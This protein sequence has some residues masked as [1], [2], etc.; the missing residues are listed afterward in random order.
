MYPT[1]KPSRLQLFLRDQRWF[2]PG[3]TID[4]WASASRPRAALPAVRSQP[5]RAECTCPMDC[6]RDHETD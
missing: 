1:P 4:A 6:I 5:A 2:V 3:R